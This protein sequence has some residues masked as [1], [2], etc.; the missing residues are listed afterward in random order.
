MLRCLIIQFRIS[1][2]MN[3]EAWGETGFDD[4]DGLITNSHAFNSLLRDNEGHGSADRRYDIN[5]L[6]SSKWPLKMKTGLGGIPG[7]LKFL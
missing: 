6:N 1:M 2:V 7:R 3:M 5:R 4:C